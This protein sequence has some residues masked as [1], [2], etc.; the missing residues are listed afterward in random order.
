MS[1]EKQSIM[2]FLEDLQ[3]GAYW[4]PLTCGTCSANGNTTTLKPKEYE[5]GVMLY[6][7]S[8][9]KNQEIPEIAIKIYESGAMESLKALYQDLRDE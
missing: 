4:H 2:E 5:T 6:C 8:C 7:P 3:S 1:E 9:K